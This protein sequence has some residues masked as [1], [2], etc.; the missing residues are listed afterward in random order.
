MLFY[1]NKEHGQ[2]RHEI[3]VDALICLALN[4]RGQ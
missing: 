2:N 1:L 3:N 4:D